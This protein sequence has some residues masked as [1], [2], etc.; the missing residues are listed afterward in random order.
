MIAFIFIFIV[1]LLSLCLAFILLISQNLSL[2]CCVE[3]TCTLLSLLLY[4][5]LFLGLFL[6]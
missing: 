2:L 5:G 1:Q 3:P 4:L 6:T